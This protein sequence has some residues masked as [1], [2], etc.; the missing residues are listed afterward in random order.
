MHVQTVTITVRLPLEHFV[1]GKDARRGAVELQGDCGAVPE[2]LLVLEVHAMAAVVR[3]AAPALLSQAALLASDVGLE[4]LGHHLFCTVPPKSLS[5]WI[6]KG[7]GRPCQRK[8]H[9]ACVRA[10]PR[11]CV[12]TPP[13]L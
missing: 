12:G 3:A 10:R 1:A 5:V 13:S 9:V 2:F 8:W 4:R 11:V 7:L 6:I